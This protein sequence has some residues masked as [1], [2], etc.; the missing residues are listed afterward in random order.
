[1]KKMLEP[2][3]EFRKDQN[4]KL[5]VDMSVPEVNV[6][7]DMMD[8][9]NKHYIEILKDVEQDCRTQLLA[10]QA[11]HILK[12][13]NT[14]R[15]MEGNAKATMKHF[16]KDYG[17]LH[18]K[19]TDLKKALTLPYGLAPSAVI[20]DLKRMSREI[21]ELMSE[22]AIFKKTIAG[23][24]HDL[25]EQDDA[26]DQDYIKVI[27][28]LN[29]GNKEL[30]KDNSALKARVEVQKNLVEQVKQEKL[31]AQIEAKALVYIFKLI[32]K[33]SIQVTK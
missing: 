30:A 18:K 7:D 22:R 16:K 5:F 15:S 13:E 24:E 26:V 14:V 20:S 6:T 8:Q 25:Q 9:F 4:G 32:K 3:I 19:Y 21:A 27:E 29:E 28:E 33:G 23:L 10:K 2:K 31:D 17:D 1:M 12:L 11:K